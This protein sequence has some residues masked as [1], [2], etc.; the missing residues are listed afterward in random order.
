MSKSQKK[1][2]LLVI[3][4]IITVSSSQSQTPVPPC[5]VDG[6]TTSFLCS[7]NRKLGDGT[8]YE[9]QFKSGIFNG[10]GKITWT[11]GT[12]YTGEFQDGQPNGYGIKVWGNDGRKYTGS[13]KNNQYSGKGTLIDAKGKILGNGV[14][15]QDKLVNPAK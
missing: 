3:A 10:K 14:W 15:D 12:V 8:K 4:S 1:I 7:G 2:T 5:P 6:R 9:G 11:D 13:F